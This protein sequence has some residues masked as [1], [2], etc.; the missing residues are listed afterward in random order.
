MCR[1]GKGGVA[2]RRGAVGAFPAGE[3]VVTGKKEVELRGCFHVED[4]A[5]CSRPT[6]PRPK[7]I[8]VLTLAC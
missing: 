6:K 7:L 8:T 2:G 4:W 1:Q 5:G 3:T